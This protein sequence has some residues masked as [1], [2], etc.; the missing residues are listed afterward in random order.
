MR[1]QTN[2]ASRCLKMGVLLCN[3]GGVFLWEG[4]ETMDLS[5]A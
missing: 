3:D 2:T 4:E 5:Q 1:T